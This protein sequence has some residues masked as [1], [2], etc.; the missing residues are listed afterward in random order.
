MKLRVRLDS[1]QVVGQRRHLVDPA[2]SGNGHGDL[3]RLLGQVPDACRVHLEVF[4][5]VVDQLAGVQLADD[6]DRLAQH[7]LA[8]VDARPGA[9][10]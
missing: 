5:P 8:I 2:V 6:G 10:S 1:D 9:D 4:T 7:G 3:D